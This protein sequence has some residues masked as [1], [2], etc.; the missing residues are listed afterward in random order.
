MKVTVENQ[1]GLNKDLKVFIDKKTIS[2]H[3]DEKYEE[4]KNKVTLKGLASE[5]IEWAEAAQNISLIM[6]AFQIKAARGN[7]GANLPTNMYSGGPIRAGQ[8]Y[9]V[10]EGGPEMIIPSTAGQ[11]MNAQR[12]LQMQQA[13]LQKSIQGMGGGGSMGGT[14]QVINSSPSTVTNILT[15]DRFNSE[16]ESLISA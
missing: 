16:I 8:P 1:K 9:I 12:T 13:S 4:V 2:S 3:M 7:I 6:R 11:V 5:N 15:Q 14:N 10:G